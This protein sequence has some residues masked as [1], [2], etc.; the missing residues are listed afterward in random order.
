MPGSALT[1]PDKSRR[2]PYQCDWGMKFLPL[3]SICLWLI[4]GGT[5]H[6]PHLKDPFLFITDT[7]SLRT[8]VCTLVHKHGCSNTEHPRLTSVTLC[9]QGF[10]AA[11]I[12]PCL[13][14]Q[15]LWQQISHVSNS[16]LQG[17]SSSSLFCSSSYI[18]FSSLFLKEWMFYLD[19]YGP[20]STE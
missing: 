11:Q 12:V 5:L 8:L 16:F 15:I 2:N 18:R 6:A 10:G 19:I 20:N 7:Q 17:F 4:C 1:L 3:R 9:L 13:F 14:L